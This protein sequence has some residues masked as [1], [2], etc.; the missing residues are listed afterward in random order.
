MIID[1]HAHYT[2]KRFDVEVPY[3][4][5]QDG[6]WAVRYAD[7]ETLFAEMQKN[8]IVGVIE[9]SIEFDGIEKQ[10]KIASKHR[11]YM[12]TAFGVHPTRCVNTAWK[13]RKELKN[14]AEK[15]DI[16]AIGE[17]GLDY[18][19]PRKKQHRLYQK[20]WFVYQLKLAD[21]LK[22]PLILH[23]RD[24]DKDALKILKKYKKRIHGG[25]VHCFTGDRLLAEKYITLGFVIG[26]G[27][28]LLCDDEAGR[29]LSDT[30]KHVPL[31]SILVETDAPF[32]FPDVS[33]LAYSG[34]QRKKLC[35][36]SLILPAVIR[37]IA[38]LKEES[39]TT[40]EN[41]LYQNT[42]RVFNLNIQASE[43]K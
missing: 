14:Y 18:H 17:T 1:S 41:I 34:N 38:E 19:L 29:I 10:R 30:V 43:D 15:A 37:K 36:S 4:C 42:L 11:A 24:A 40:V 20:R 26:I 7:R 13:N 25:V 16:I 28:K 23:T 12:S 35:N 39:Y 22:L 33:E 21:H 3:L 31:S 6:E 32:V 27:G 9:P 5:A 8:N 2:H